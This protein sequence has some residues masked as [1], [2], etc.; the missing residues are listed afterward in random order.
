MTSLL[1]P[2]SKFQLLAQFHDLLLRHGH[3]VIE[4]FGPDSS[5]GNMDLVDAFQEL[6]SDYYLEA[7]ALFT[8]GGEDVA[9]VRFFLLRQ[10]HWSGG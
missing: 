1:P 6:S 7:G 3:F 2:N 5:P 9:D 4:Y 10:G 8:A